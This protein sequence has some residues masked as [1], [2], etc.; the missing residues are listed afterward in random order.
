M[1]FDAIGVELGITGESARKI[2]A[3]AILK[4]QIAFGVIQ[5]LPKTSSEQIQ[6]SRNWQ[7]KHRARY[8]AYKREY[9]RKHRK[10]AV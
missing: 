3:R 9:N 6:W 2:Y 8:L 7:V 1:T 4:L 10:R 5:A